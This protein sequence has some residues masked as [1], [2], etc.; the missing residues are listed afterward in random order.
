MNSEKKKMQIGQKIHHVRE[1]NSTMEACNRL[2][3]L[4]EPN[5]T[6][7]ST[8]YQESGRGRFKRKWVSP[9]GD[10]IQMSIL[11]RP[12]QQELKYLNIFASMAVLA[13]CE[14]TLGVDGSIKW[15][16]D[17]QI[18]GKK[19]A[20]ILTETV[21]EGEKVVSSVIG[22]GLNVNLDVKMQPDIEETATSL[23]YEKGRYINRSIILK[24]LIKKLNLYYS[25]ISDGR[26][27]TQRWSDKLSTIGEEVTLSFGE[28][29]D[30]TVL[31]GLAESINDDGG[32]IIRKADGSLFTA[33]AGEVTLAKKG[34]I[35]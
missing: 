5:G 2:A 7:V 35:L 11:L 9:S 19:I 12:N 18:N 13:T 31:V 24:K 23:K 34:R 15:P 30:E 14:Q 4:G 10:N 33:N 17:V 8:N 32:L 3:I 21:L 29:P 28:N 26:S 20:G 25:K 27:L 1:I 6:I 16:N 22:I